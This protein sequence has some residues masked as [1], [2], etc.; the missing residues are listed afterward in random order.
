MR[1]LVPIERKVDLVDETDRAM[2]T[3]RRNLDHHAE[4]ERRPENGRAA[5]G[6]VFDHIGENH[7]CLAELT[8]HA[9]E[10]EHDAHVA[11]RAPG[12]Q[13]R[14]ELRLEQRHVAQATSRMLRRTEP[15]LESSPAS[16][17]GVR[18]PKSLSAP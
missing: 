6:E 5:F 15:G 18:L 4:R 7:L 2:I 8:E 11:E 1:S 13:D 17:L 16:A 3:A 12:S 9:D 14:P 10:R